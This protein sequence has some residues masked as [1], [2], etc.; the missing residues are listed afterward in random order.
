MKKRIRQAVKGGVIPAMMAAFL[1]VNLLTGCVKNE[2]LSRDAM[3]IREMTEE[4][5]TS[6]FT[7]DA[8]AAESIPEY[9]IK[10]LADVEDMNL[11]DTCEIWCEF[12]NSPQDDYFQYLTITFIKKEEGWEAQSIGLEL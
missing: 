12:K 11:N 7:G 5:F 3:K 2:G 10:G 9:K 6:Y 8:G 4:I 1:G